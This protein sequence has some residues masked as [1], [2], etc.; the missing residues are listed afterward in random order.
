MGCQVI[1]EAVEYLPILIANTE[2]RRSAI[3][4]SDR[5]DT[6][7]PQAVI[8]CDD[9]MYSKFV[10]PIEPDQNLSLYRSIAN[11]LLFHRLQ[12]S[13]HRICIRDF[14]GIGRRIIGKA[15][16]DEHFFNFAIIHH[17]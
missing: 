13:E 6:I 11:T 3:V 9:L 17:H 1:L 5:K 15:G 7:A 2:G 14:K 10:T 12:I 4:G 8:K 16:F